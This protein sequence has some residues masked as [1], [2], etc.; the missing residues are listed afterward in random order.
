MTISDSS[1]MMLFWNMPEEI[2]RREATFS[3]NQIK[4]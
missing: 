3:V 1:T 2:N 4:Q